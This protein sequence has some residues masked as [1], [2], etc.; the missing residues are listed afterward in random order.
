MELYEDDVNEKKSNIP[1]II[2]ICIGVLVILIIVIIFGIIYLQNLMLKITLD[3][4]RNNDIE[5]VLY[6]P[7]NFW[8]SFYAILRVTG[9]FLL[10][11]S[12]TF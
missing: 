11:S 1:M 5:N 9:I 12:L 7:S 4:Q 2:G 6:I 3:N 8:K 10:Y